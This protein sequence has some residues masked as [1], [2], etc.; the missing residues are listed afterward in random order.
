M[1]SGRTPRT[2]G[3]PVSGQIGSAIA[4]LLE[5]QKQK[6]HHGISREL[7]IERPLLRGHVVDILPDPMI[8]VGGHRLLELPPLDGLDHAY[9]LAT[10]EAQ[11]RSAPDCRARCIQPLCRGEGGLDRIQ[12]IGR[13]TLLCHE[14]ALA[15]LWCFFKSSLSSLNW[16]TP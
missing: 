1:V 3:W 4:L 8:R 15:P 9:N 7:D 2:T 10:A 16:S 14:E 12:V 13:F 11:S 5:R 6:L